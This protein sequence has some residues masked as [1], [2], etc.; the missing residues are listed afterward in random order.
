M[1]LVKCP[2]CE[3]YVKPE[4]SELWCATHGPIPLPEPQKERPND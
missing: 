2:R 3:L 1:K 4:A